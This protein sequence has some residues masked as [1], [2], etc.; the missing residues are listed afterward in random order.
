VAGY[1]GWHDWY[2]GTTS[3]RR[4]IPDAVAG[5]VSAVPFAALDALQEALE[6]TRGEVAAVILEPAGATEPPEGYLQAAVDL[7]R[8]HGALA[9]FDEVITGF[10]LAPGGAQ[11]HYGVQADLACFG[12]ALGNGMPISALAGRAE[13]MDVLHDVFFSGTH[14]GETLSLAAAA[15][16][17]DVLAAERVH[18]HLW[19]LGRRLQEGVGRAIAEHGVGEWVSCSGAAPWTLVLVREPHQRA[20]GL[21]A[22]T[23]LQQELLKRG[24]LYNGSHFVSASHTEADVDETIAAYDGALAVMAAALPDD[25]DAHLEAAPVATV[26]RA[27]Q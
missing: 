2:I 13:H 24:L 19:R 21:A 1:H 12:K 8:E 5:L 17:L 10:R 3:R 22:K 15:A 9:V 6:R 27:V 18:E 7:T 20:D 4:G 26:F 16:T 25:V 11:E 14:G 23:L